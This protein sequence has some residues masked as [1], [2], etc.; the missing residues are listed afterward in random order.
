MDAG[1]PKSSCPASQTELPS[2]PHMFYVSHHLSPGDT[3]AS[4]FKPFWRYSSDTS[5]ILQLVQALNWVSVYV[6]VGRLHAGILRDAR[7]SERTNKLWLWGWTSPYIPA[8]GRLSQEHYECK[9]SLSYI[10]RLYLRKG[11]TFLPWRLSQPNGG[12]TLTYVNNFNA[13]SKTH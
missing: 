11:I 3:S 8:L 7:H 6:S 13:S 5:L 12:H 2:Q 9:A 1:D 10:I 4:L